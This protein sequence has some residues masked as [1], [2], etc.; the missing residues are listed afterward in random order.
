MPLSFSS[1]SQSRQSVCSSSSRRRGTSALVRLAWRS[2]SGIGSFTQSLAYHCR[3][4]TDREG[5][6]IV[7]HQLRLTMAARLSRSPENLAWP[8]RRS[9]H[10]ADC[11]ECVYR[12]DAHHCDSSPRVIMAAWLSRPPE[13]LASTENSTGAQHDKFTVP[14]W[15]DGH[16]LSITCALGLVAHKH[17][18]TIVLSSWFM[19]VR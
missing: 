2:K 5:A 6:H 19:A 4:C 12:E 1:W 8:Q 17:R 7:I 16:A 14:S 15:F 11:R 10:L 9:E 3:E 13:H 18:T